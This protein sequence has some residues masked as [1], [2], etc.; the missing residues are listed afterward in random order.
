MSINI[1]GYRVS[2]ASVSQCADEMVA[3]S[4]SGKRQCLTFGCLNP[5]SYVV[6]K[7]DPL[8]SEALRAMDWLVPDGVGVIIG[9]KILGN[10][11]LERVTGPDVMEAVLCRLNQE[12]GS[13][14]FLGSSLETLKRIE[15]RIS[16]EYP[17][18]R[19][20]GTFSPPFKEQFSAT[21]ND[22]MVSR[23]NEASP[24]I[25]W[26]GL[27]APKQE[28]W[29]FEN[30]NQLNVGAA[31]AVGAAFDFYSGHVKRSP[32]FFRALGLE[33]LPRLLRQPRRLWRRTVISAP[34][35]LFDV[36]ISSF[37]RLA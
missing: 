16:R 36:V 7:K 11:G 33:W 6:A 23:V 5:H 3:A 21:E 10:R 29:L 14:F 17:L 24:D 28:K 32:P 25:L 2:T 22:E 19:L 13:V 20:S 30:R 18:V 34:A 8:F 1:L 15:K 12:G 9:A 35:F 4:R 37:R 27:T 26:V 31:G